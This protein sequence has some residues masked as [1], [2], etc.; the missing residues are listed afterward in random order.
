[1]ASTLD[2]LK[3]YTTVVADTGDFKCK[4]IQLWEWHVTAEQVCGL[5]IGATSMQ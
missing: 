3:K 5:L 4:A 2:Q 1:M